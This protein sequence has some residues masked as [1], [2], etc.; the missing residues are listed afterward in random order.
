M[1]K[2]LVL[3]T[4]GVN[5]D[6]E[7]VAALEMAGAEV[8]LLHINELINN[9]KMDDYKIMVIPGG[10]SYGDD[11]GAGV[12]LGNEIKMNLKEQLETFVEE[13]K[14][15]MGICNGFQV[16]MHTGI[17][18]GALAQNASGKFEC[19]WVRLKASPSLFTKDIDYIEMPV[20]HGEGR[21]IGGGGEVVF[22]YVDEKGNTGEYPENPNGSVNGIA[23]ITNEKGNVLG[24]MPHPERNLYSTSNPEWTRG[25]KGGEGLKIYQNA[26]R[27]AEEN[28]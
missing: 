9:K 10:F 26:V 21:L 8:D 19:R 17:L 5:C 24:M 28:L 7:T 23:G 1:V 2:T 4:V 16:L 11:L 12:V 15:L 27:Y 25:K 3:R 20:A 22:R 6:G 13:G 18:K 14:I